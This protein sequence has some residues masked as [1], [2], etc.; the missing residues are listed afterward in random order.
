M[1]NSP[2]CPES[3]MPFGEPMNVEKLFKIEGGQKVRAL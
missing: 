1:I 3:I 2:F